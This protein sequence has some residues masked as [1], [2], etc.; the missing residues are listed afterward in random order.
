MAD[1]VLPKV[2]VIDRQFIGI[3]YNPSIGK[4]CLVLLVYTIS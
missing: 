2:V 1:K 3:E 4:E